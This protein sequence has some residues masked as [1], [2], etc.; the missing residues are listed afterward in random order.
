MSRKAHNDGVQ[1]VSAAD[2]PRCGAAVYYGTPVVWFVSES[3]T[4]WHHDNRGPVEFI[5]GTKF[6]SQ[7][8]GCPKCPQALQAVLLA[9]VREALKEFVP[10]A[11]R[12][13]TRA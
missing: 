5:S 8:P 12:Q 4:K 7:Q 10:Y 2:C 9:A 13:T 3:A 1:F 11:G 6:T